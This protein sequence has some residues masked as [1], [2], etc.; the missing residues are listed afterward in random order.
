MITPEQRAKG[1]KKSKIKTYSF[2]FIIITFISMQFI[3]AYLNGEGTI[4]STNEIVSRNLNSFNFFFI[5]NNSKYF[6][7]LFFAFLIYSMVILLVLA[8]NTVNMPEHDQKG[9]AKWADPKSTLK[10]R[11][12]EPTNNTI[13]TQNVQISMDNEKTKKN[14]NTL[15]IG[16]PSAGKTFQYISPNLLNIGKENIVVNDVKGEIIIMHGKH[17]IEKGYDVR[18]LNTKDMSKSLKFNPLAYIRKESDI[19]S[20]AK[21]LSEALGD[22]GK[23]GDDAFWKSAKENL[24]TACIAF[25]WERKETYP[26]QCN[27]PFINE[28]LRMA[29]EKV[30]HK[31]NP[32]QS[33]FDKL[34][35]AYSSTEANRTKLSSRSYGNFK[36]N[37][38]RTRANVL[39]TLSSMLSCLDIE[40]ARQLLSGEDELH[41]EELATNEKI[42]VFL[43]SSDTDSTWNFLTTLAV[44]LGLNKICD[45][46][47]EYPEKG[48]DVIFWIDEFANGSRIKDCDKIVAVC[49]SRRIAMKIIIQSIIQLE[50]LYKDEWKIIVESCDTKLILGANGDS[51]E[52]V[53]KMLGKQG[54]NVKTTSQTK[55]Y[56][57]G[58]WSINNNIEARDLLTPD[59]VTRLNNDAVITIRGE[60]PIIDKKYETWKDERFKLMGKVAKGRAYERNY[61]FD[62][63]E[64]R[65]EKIKKLQNERDEKDNLEKEIA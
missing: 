48:V 60:Q 29:E 58:S 36:M 28:L 57:G 43:C 19:L 37:K 8:D 44:S 16:P 40:E 10:Y 5:P 45:I 42:A 7:F 32:I 6:I 11:D 3:R 47:D 31:G 25:V 50:K 9:S 52:F 22:G 18:V 49:R 54:L 56:R 1:R 34:F 23:S 61:F 35:E 30:D 64:Y 21:M 12:K 63:G 14:N 13:F 62:P 15:V 65:K 33:D 55:Q 27:L 38:D 53:S 46:R 20:I 24:I 59:E 51:A 41:L 17:L 2:C 26:E 4:K 39:T